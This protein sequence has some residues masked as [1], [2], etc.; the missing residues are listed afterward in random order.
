MSKE[1]FNELRRQAEEQLAGRERQI[2]SLDRADLAKMAH[3]L[4]VHQV[5]LELQNEE[6]RRARVEVEE[7]RDLYVD[8][9]D[10]APV[11]YLTLDENTRIVEANL[12]ASQ[13][14]G[15]IR[16]NVFKTRFTKF[17]NSEE[18]DR[19]H[20][21]QRKALGSGD[22]QTL[23][24]KMQKADGTSFDAQLISVKAGQGRLRVAIIDITERKKVEQ[25][26][27]EF[28]GMVSHE[29]R[30][31]L[32]V[33]MGSVNTAMDKR[34]SREE[35]GELLQAAS[36][37][38]DLLASIMDNLLEFSRYRAGRLTLDREL[39]DISE[40]ARKIVDKV[41]QQY[42]AR[43][44]KLDIS[45]ELPPVLVDPVRLERIIYNLVENAFKYSPVGTTVRVF[46][47]QKK[48]GLIVGVSDHG[49]G[50]SIEDQQRLFEPFERFGTANNNKGVGLGLVVCKRL[51]EAHGGHIW[52][53]SKPGEGT[54]FLF[55]IPHEKKKRT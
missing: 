36:S 49:A 15:E 53:E 2:E 50:L 4:S 16:A 10:F 32:T 30:T 21:H 8:L 6:L 39:T 11:G 29:L 3:E 33:I 23:E 26:K 1:N 41:H 38:C 45:N 18:S 44:A 27:D 43:N 7:A 25:L 28:V 13:M 14:L 51:V 31:P 54:T 24:L 37:N 12:M 46:A 40:M 19:F 34:I 55:S 22:R 35:S 5:E 9:Y 52:A 47:Q 42:P 20:F 48:E 17:I